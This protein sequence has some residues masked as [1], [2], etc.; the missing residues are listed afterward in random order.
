[1][2]KQYT[3]R[4]HVTDIS[5]ALKASFHS[6]VSRYFS[7]KLD[8]LT[9]LFT[10]SLL[11]TFPISSTCFSKTYNIV[12]DDPAPR[13]EVFAF[14]RSLLNQRMPDLVTEVS[15]TSSSDSLKQNEGYTKLV[16][17]EKRVSN[18]RM[19][20]ELGVELIHPTY[21]SGLEDIINQMI[22]C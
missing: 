7:I 19:K 21:K 16:K 13:T 11:I 10:Y 22:I 9:Q 8:L 2:S 3:S 17:G 5:Q 12:D 18:G 20:N 6:P 14:A 15:S 4:V 1:M